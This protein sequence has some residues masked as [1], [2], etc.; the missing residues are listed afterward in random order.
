[1][2]LL[3]TDVVSNFRKRP[4]H[5][6]LLKWFHSV[7]PDEFTVSV[8]T[9][10]EIQSG[11]SLLRPT[12]PKKADEL[13]GWLDGFVLAG[14]F[15]FLPIDTDVARLYAR[16]FANP[17]LKNFVFPDPNSKRPK[18]GADLVIAATAIVCDATLVTLDKDD[19]LR[20][21]AEIP[22]PSIYDP[23]AMEWPVGK[24]KYTPPP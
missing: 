24:P 23:I 16:M 4:P 12:D 13:E 10:F 20:V 14:N 19:F 8:M 11:T 3:D 18:S 6:N 1:M 22:I 21:H 15:K 7:L 5:P 9:I 2:Y 17:A